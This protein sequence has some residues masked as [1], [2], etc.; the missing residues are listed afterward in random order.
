MVKRGEMGKNSGQLK[1]N[2]LCYKFFTYLFVS[3]GGGGKKLLWGGWGI[4]NGNVI[5]RCAII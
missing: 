3:W 5:T 4:L 2:Y 1:R